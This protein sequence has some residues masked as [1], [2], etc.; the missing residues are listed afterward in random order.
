M[1]Y[2]KQTRYRKAP[3]NWKKTAGTV[4]KT[5]STALKVASFVAGMVNAEKNYF[6]SNDS[7]SP[8][9]NGTLYKVLDMA[10]GTDVL[11]RIG[12]S[13]LVKS[14]Y[15]NASC[16]INAS[17]TKS[18]V[19]IVIFV[20]KMNQGSDPAVS[21]IISVTGNGFAPICPLNVDHTSRYRILLDQKFALSNNGVQ[22]RT[23]KKYLKT[24]F[25]AK[26]TG[27]ASTDVYKNQVYL[28][29][30]SDENT[31]APLVNTCV[32]IGYYDN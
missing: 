29:L 8:T 3:Y 18:L 20:D 31:N 2:Q 4:A 9:Y 22:Y 32:R 14:I 30:V 17:A 24:K 21:D 11:Q 23:Y 26:F 7:T 16:A 25:H 5:A 12:N 1:R 13:I 19:R 10:Q 28:L 15:L 6:D 27:S